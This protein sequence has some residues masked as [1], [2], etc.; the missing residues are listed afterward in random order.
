MGALEEFT[1]MKNQGM[2]E[3]DIIN[4]LRGKYSPKE[5][6]DAMSQSQI[7]NAIANE[8]MTDQNPPT[9]GGYSESPQTQE[10]NYPDDAGSD[11]YSSQ[12][13]Q[14]YY[15]QPNENYAPEQNYA[16]GYAGGGTDN[17]IEVAEQVVEQKLSK[18]KKQIDNLTEFK[19]VAQTRIE[20]NT[21]RLKRIEATLDKLQLAILDKIGTYQDTLNSIKNEMNMMQDSFSKVAKGK[22]HKKKK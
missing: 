9:P 3:N 6:N 22:I 15:P 11:M 10:M 20:M 8:T 1:Q 5:I 19:T 16:Q 17:M 13:Q 4:N 14:E 7:K 2:N 18:L 21:E 12:S